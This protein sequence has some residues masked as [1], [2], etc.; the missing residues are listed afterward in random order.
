MN[1]KILLL[2]FI[3]Y[4]PTAHAAL[5]GLGGDSVMYRLLAILVCAILAGIFAGRLNAAGF[6]KVLTFIPVFLLLSVLG[7]TVTEFFYKRDVAQKLSVKAAREAEFQ[8]DPLKIAACDR[9]VFVLKTLLDAPLSDSTKGYLARIVIECTV[10]KDKS[11]LAKFGLLMPYLV[12]GQWSEVS[13]DQR[14][15]YPKYCEVLESIHEV[16]SIEFL[17]LLV[18]AG[19]PLDCARVTDRAPVWWHGLEPKHN[20]W[21]NRWQAN[22]LNLQVDPAQMLKWLEF[23]QF[24]GVR[25]EDRYV[26]VNYHGA[27]VEDTML[28]TVISGSSAA[29]ILLALNAGCDPH[30]DFKGPGSPFNDWKW[31][32]DSQKTGSNVLYAAQLTDSEI[33]LINAKMESFRQRK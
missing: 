17:K 32:I 9:D 16:R 21:G 27:E 15:K 29:I 2:F 4:I 3:T 14:A 33:D 28:S 31:R 30:V 20:K 18:Q 13:R 1:F 24:N 11:D 10:H 23:I 12:A 6:E 5:D 19:R 25:L 8:N 7:V 26:P 22:V